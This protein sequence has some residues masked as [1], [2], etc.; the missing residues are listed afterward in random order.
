M[1]FPDAFQN[2]L[3]IVTTA[4]GEGSGAKM[5][6]TL[7]NTRQCTKYYRQI[8][9]RIVGYHFSSQL[10]ATLN[11]CLIYFK[12]TWPL[13]TLLEHIHNKFEMNRTKIK[14]G[15]QLGRKEVTHNSKSDLPLSTLHLK[16]KLPT[17]LVGC[18]DKSARKLGVENSTNATAPHF[19]QARS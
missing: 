12:I 8:T 17:D 18:W 15:C 4:V 1:A 10:T 7:I 16:E 14:G 2:G 19:L 5:R 13:A 3:G 9:L 11:L 6:E